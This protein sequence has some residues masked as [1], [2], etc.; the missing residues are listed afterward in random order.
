MV[1]N[2]GAQENLGRIA[3]EEH[4]HAIDASRRVLVDEDG[5]FFNS[6]N[7][8]PVE[9]SAAS[10]TGMEIW[11]GV[12]WQK[13]GGALIGTL[14]GNYSIV[15][16]SVA[17][18]NT[19]NVF[20]NRIYGLDPDNST[21]N[22]LSSI[23]CTWSDAYTGNEFGIPILSYGHNNNWVTLYSNES[24]GSLYVT[25]TDSSS[26]EA[27]AMDA[28]GRAGYQR[29]TDGS[30]SVSITGTALDVNVASG[31]I[32]ANIEGDY[33]DDSPFT[34]GIDKG[35]MVGGFFTADIIDAGDF[36]AFKINA[37]RELATTVELL[38]PDGTNT[39]PSMDA[40]A[41]AGYQYIT[42]GSN[43]VAIDSNSLQVFLNDS[44]IAYYNT[45][46]V[47][48]N[49]IYGWDGSNAKK[50]GVTLVGTD[51]VMYTATAGSV[52]YN[53]THNVFQNGMYLWT[54]TTWK[55]AGVVANSAFGGTKALLP[56]GGKYEAT[57]TT[58]GD[59]DATP[60]L[61][62]YNGR[63][64]VTDFFRDI[65]VTINRNADATVASVVST[66]GTRTKTE[67]I[68]RNVDGTVA[69]ISVA[70]T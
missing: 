8:L 28:V 43:T 1:D 49:M 33:V 21:I 48:Q 26:N 63:L 37:N 15:G 47:F 54:G 50:I 7:P 66:D 22:P 9:V 45:D 6:G 39:M 11:D 53:S 13:L 38:K 25:R 62:D 23:A 51:Y 12:A 56:I 35:L 5:N 42:D 70:I 59:G 17:F 36:G 29:L 64:Q 14:Y 46:D 60:L 27:P 10:S 30:T 61:M 40:A 32:I 34:A 44:G 52:A 69:S 65:D 57:P 18:D 24:S 4:V 55:E 58:Y 68:N 19:N 3:N 20:Q 67:T 2:E 16:G 31:T 41:R